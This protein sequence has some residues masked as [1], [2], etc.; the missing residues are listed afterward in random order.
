MD[1]RKHC[2]DWSVK[3]YARPAVTESKATYMNT[4][5]GPETAHG[6]RTVMKSVANKNAY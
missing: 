5:N 2:L 3:I 6:D 1:E 4:E